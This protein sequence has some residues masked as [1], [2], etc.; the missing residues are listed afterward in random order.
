MRNVSPPW[1]SA[2]AGQLERDRQRLLVA[3]I[4]L[5]GRLLQTTGDDFAGGEGERT[6]A[7]ARTGHDYV[8]LV[9]VG[10]EAARLQAKLEAADREPTAREVDTAALL[11]TQMNEL[12][13]AVRGRIPRG[14]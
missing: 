5:R 9:E 14:S 6:E 12:A 7:L 13:D 8:A 11:L 2:L 1:S 3:F 4:E 10:A